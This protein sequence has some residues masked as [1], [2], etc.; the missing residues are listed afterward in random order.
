MEDGPPEGAVP[1]D[2]EAEPQLTSPDGP[3]A[4][5]LDPAMLEEYATRIFGRDVKDDIKRRK[6]ENGG[7]NAPA[8]TRSPAKSSRTRS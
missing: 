3:D 4:S 5:E 7:T 1:P 6:D 8:G 2:L